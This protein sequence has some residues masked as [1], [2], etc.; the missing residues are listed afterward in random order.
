M[1]SFPHTLVCGLKSQM[2]ESCPGF[3]VISSLTFC[4]HGV[5]FQNMCLSI[6]KLSLSVTN[7]ERRK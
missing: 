4:S 2:A 3:S 5:Q 7:I 1:Y 6:I